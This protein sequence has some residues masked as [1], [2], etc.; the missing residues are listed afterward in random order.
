MQIS[1]L[2]IPGKK[3]RKR[4]GRGPGSGHGKTAGRG[5]KGHKARSGFK[6][7]HA[8]EGGQMPL[9]RR[10]PKRG[11]RPLDKTVYQLVNVQNLERFTEGQTVD[12][13]ALKAGGLIQS[14][15]R[16]VK[17]LGSGSLSKRLTV[18]A[19]RFSQSARD[20]IVQ[21]GGQAV[22]PDAPAA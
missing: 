16:P 20:K 1:E 5:T 15:K 14:L 2:N 4:L 12:A 21:A 18:R 9:Q 22:T 3:K 7:K 17:I 19:D 11:F 6:R 8:F 13:S 10:I